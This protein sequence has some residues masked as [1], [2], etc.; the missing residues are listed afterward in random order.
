MFLNMQLRRC[1]TCCTFHGQKVHRVIFYVCPRTGL[2]DP[3]I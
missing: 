2:F 1:K 3:K